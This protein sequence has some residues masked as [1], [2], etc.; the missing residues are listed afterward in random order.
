MINTN[1]KI[2]K[3]IKQKLLILFTKVV[4]QYLKKHIL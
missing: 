4:L 2:Q 1:K 3:L